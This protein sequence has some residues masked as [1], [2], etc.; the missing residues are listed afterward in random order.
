MPVLTPGRALRS[1]E[2]RLVVENELAPGRHLF[3]L[4]VVDDGG[5]ESAPVELVVNVVRRVTPPVG[6]RDPRIL[7]PRLRDPRIFR[8]S[9]PPP[10]DPEPIRPIRPIRPTR[11]IR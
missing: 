11:P 7:D 8:P 4:V 5:L 6:P 3:Q 9:P 10:P 1:R 2:P